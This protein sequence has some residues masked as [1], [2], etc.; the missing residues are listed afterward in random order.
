MKKRKRHKEKCEISK[1]QGGNF[2]TLLNN[3]QQLYKE[4][5]A[6]TAVEGF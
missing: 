2:M 4:T 1:A 5:T 3:Q 6:L